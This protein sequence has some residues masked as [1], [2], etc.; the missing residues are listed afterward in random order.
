MQRYRA[1]IDGLRAL[2]VIA[3]VL[4]HADIRGFDGGYVGVDVFFVISGFLITNFILSDQRQARFRIRDFYKRRIRRIFPALFT[5]MLLCWLVAYWLLL[6]QDFAEFGASAAWATLFFSNIHFWQLSSYFGG[7][8]ELRPLL[9]TWSLAIE[10]QFYI[11]YPVALV[12]LHRFAPGKIPHG[13]VLCFGASL[14]VSA[15]AA[16]AHPHAAFYLTPSRAWE[17]MLGALL[18]TGVA[19]KPSGPRGRNAL[20]ALGLVLILYSIFAYSD[21]TP[22]PGLAALAP[23]IGTALIIH[24]GTHGTT[25]VGHVLSSR[26]VVF[27]GL[28]SYSLYLWHWPVLVMFRHY[29]SVHD[30]PLHLKLF[31]LALSTAFAIVSWRYVERP[32]RNRRRVAW[33]M[34][35][36][37]SASATA[38]MLAVGVTAFVSDGLPRRFDDAVI[39]LASA[40]RD[41]TLDGRGCINQRTPDAVRRGNMCAVVGAGAATPSFLLW[42]DSHAATLYPAINKAAARSGRSGLMATAS[43]CPP[44]IGVKSPSGMRTFRCDDFND[45]VMRTS[46]A[47]DAIELVIMNARWAFYAHGST[48]DVEARRNPVIA[49]G[50]A[51]TSGPAEIKAVFVRG[52]RRTLAALRSAGKRVVIVGPIPEIGWTVPRTLAMQR[53]TGR[54]WP[55]S[56]TFPEFLER[57]SFVILTLRKLAAEFSA[58]LV[59]PHAALCDK[60]ECAVMRGDQILYSDSNHLSLTGARQIH[61]IF[62]PIFR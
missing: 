46:L 7:A 14:A 48:Y 17:L 30:L 21:E 52:L 55:I 3:V 60:N 12:F 16:I 49:D 20:A 6:P 39:K 4:F 2:A 53:Y 50:H 57:Q 44:L 56:P 37:A 32:F 22:F 40:R 45:A 47:D 1:D 10:E 13:L 58:D 25:G 36:M 34:V 24:G 5:V 61:A 31:A 27:V 43:G 41:I 62:E 51:Q 54:S 59:F 29:M 38:L 9:H 35:A 18:A 33:P 42:G 28:I 19:P 11:V 15:W 8:A 26:P 23:C